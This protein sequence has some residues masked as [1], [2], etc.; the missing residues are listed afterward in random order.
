MKSIVQYRNFLGV[1]R[2]PFPFAALGK[3]VAPAP[4]LQNATLAGQVAPG[5]RVIARTP[6]QMEQR[7][8]TILRD[9]IWEGG[10]TSV[11]Y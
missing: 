1:L 7:G 6:E 3:Q 8:D 4:M 2:A 5:V 9:T 10:G 11:D